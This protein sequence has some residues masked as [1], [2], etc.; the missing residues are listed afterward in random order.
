MSQT[1]AQQIKSPV[2]VSLQSKLIKTSVLSSVIAGL[3]ALV[4][5][6]SVITYQ[7]MSLQDEMMDEIADVLLASDISRHAGTQVDELSE[8]FDIQYQ[9]KYNN[10]L[11]TQSEDYDLPQTINTSSFLAHEN[12][13]FAWVN[14]SLYRV[15][16]SDDQG[17]S[18]KLYQPLK[19]RFNAVF[20]GVL[21]F[22]GILLILWVLQ[23]GMLH[24]AVKKLFKSVLQLSKEISE[25][26]AQDLTP[27]QSPQ[28]EL[29]ELQPIIHQLNQ[30]LSRVEQSLQAEQRFTSDASHELR[31]PLSAVQMRLQLIKRKYNDASIS[32]DLDQ[33]QI[34]VSRGVN[35]LENLLLL[36]RLDPSQADTLPRSKFDLKDTLKEVEKALQPFILDKQVGLKIDAEA[37]QIEANA[38]L[39][40]SCI[41]NLVDNAIRY[42]KGRDDIEIQLSQQQNH[43]IMMIKNAGEYVPDT[44]IERMGE[45]FYRELGNRTHGSGLGLSIC[46][47]IVALH[48]GKLEFENPENGG[49]IVLLELPISR[50]FFIE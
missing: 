49:L 39:I 15:Y 24:F 9:L 32:N 22:A 23:W 7:T 21:S 10:Q 48:D 37:V 35:V 29:K 44:V 38:E 27:V 11:L 5:M 45:R 43:A 6:L 25:K 46:K 14:H 41:R 40:Y 16:R 31:S 17:Q 2:P 28:P 30:M 13:A 1:D 33:I 3:I 20:E 36:A 26:T 18:L 12:F 19:V 4:L 50:T 42:T 47:K 8:Q 34:D